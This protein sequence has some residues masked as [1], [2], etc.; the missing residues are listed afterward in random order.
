MNN[1]RVRKF[2]EHFTAWARDR[3]DILAVA[4]VGSYARG[5]ARSDSDIDLVIITTNRAQYLSDIRWT[6]RFGEPARNQTEDYGL[7]TS[8]RVWY[9]DGLE[10]EYGFTDERW[11]ALPL[12]KG[13]RQVIADGMQVLF[14]R[15]DVLS[16]HQDAKPTHKAE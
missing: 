3:C 5:A 4:L 6:A 2:L 7:V 9:S 12:D 13:T 15:R 11:V 8:L 14:E 1:E 10:V 16:R